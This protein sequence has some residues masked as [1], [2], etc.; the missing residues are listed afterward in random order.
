MV[1]D[2]IVLEQERVAVAAKAQEKRVP[3]MYQVV[4]H[5][6]DYTPMDFVVNVLEHF[7]HLDRAIA[8]RLMYEVHT[9]GRAVCGIFSRDI[10]ETKVDQ[11]VGFARMNEHP[12]L[13]SV[14]ES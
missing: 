9:R 7:F 6:D 12:L 10:A 2:N 8:T 1:A 3:E 11:V 5:N 14:E 4:M 13:C